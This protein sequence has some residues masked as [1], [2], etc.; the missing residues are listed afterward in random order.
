VKVC[1]YVEGGGSQTKSQNVTACRKAFHVFFERALGDKPK[2]R[3]IPSGSRDEAYRD[4]CR[5]L[6]ND[7]DSFAVLL[8][9]SEDPVAS[10]RTAAE[11]L[12]KLDRWTNRLPSAQVHLMVQ[13]MEAWFLADRKALAEYYG[14]KFNSSALPG[15]PKI[16]EIPKRDVMRGLAGATKLTTKGV[17]HKTRHGF[18]LLEHIDPAAVRRASAHADAL[19][20]LLR[21]KLT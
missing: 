16:E 17:Y 13:C 19:V 5:S 20:E 7:Q 18:E 10:G 9:D 15:N 4:F 8:V 11:H 12:R 21:A 14:D 6:E 2:P 3:I 1:V